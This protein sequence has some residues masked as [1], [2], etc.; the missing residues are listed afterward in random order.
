[1]ALISRRLAADNFIVA[2]LRDGQDVARARGDAGFTVV[3]ALIASVL[4]AVLIFGLTMTVSSAFRSVKQSRVQQQA[5]ALAAEGLEFAR[6]VDWA[7]LATFP[8]HPLSD[9]HV[10]GGTPTT[11]NGPLL[12]LPAG[13]TLVDVDSNPS[14]AIAR[15]INETWDD[16]Q[17]GVFSYVTEVE[18]DLRRVVVVVEWQ[19]GGTDHV[20]WTSSLVSETTTQ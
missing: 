18:A 9:P 20:E 13:E 4:A 5:T 16:V 10:V 17:F 15:E 2:Y 12:G 14:A 11:L 1:M 6:S 8:V 7:E 3:E 19:V